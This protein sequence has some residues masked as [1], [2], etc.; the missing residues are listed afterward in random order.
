MQSKFC[1]LNK[2]KCLLF[3]ISTK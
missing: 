2:I 1:R 3:T